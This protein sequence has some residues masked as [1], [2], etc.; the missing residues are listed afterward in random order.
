MINSGHIP[1]RY[2]KALYEFA[3]INNAQLRL[4]DEIRVVLKNIATY[5][6]FKKA[7]LNPIHKESEKKIL[8]YKKVFHCD[9]QEIK[10]GFV[11]H[12]K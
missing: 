7:M 1:I 6:S 8:I 2:A 11:I 5:P 9:K 4:Y 12:V 10:N 3:V